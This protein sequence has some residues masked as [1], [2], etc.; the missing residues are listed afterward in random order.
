ME[1][2]VTILPERAIH[3]LVRNKAIQ[4]FIKQYW[5]G[6]HR[7]QVNPQ[8]F[9]QERHCNPVGRKPFYRFLECPWHLVSSEK[10]KWVMIVWMVR[11]FYCPQF[12]EVDVGASFICQDECSHEATQVID[13]R[14]FDDLWILP[15]RLF[16]RFSC[17]VII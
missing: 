16:T 12:L 2:H 8:W 7:L 10:F 4:I 11:G 15:T 9:C 6:A 5:P 14:L 17:S 1:H 3:R 13:P